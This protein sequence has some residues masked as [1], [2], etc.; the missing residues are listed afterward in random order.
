M[1]YWERE[2]EIGTDRAK[3]KMRWGVHV[4]FDGCDVFFWKQGI[5][6][7]VFINS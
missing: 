6:E 5:N 7:N 1:K 2:V 3:R 4:R